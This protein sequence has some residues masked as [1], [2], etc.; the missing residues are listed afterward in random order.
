MSLDDLSGSNITNTAASTADTSDQYDTTDA[1]D[2]AVSLADGAPAADP[3][4]A[5]RMPSSAAQYRASNDPVVRTASDLGPAENF[6]L[7][8]VTFSDN[9]KLS[10]GTGMELGVINLPTYT[11]DRSTGSQI[12]AFVVSR[13][14]APQGL[15]GVN[16]IGYTHLESGNRSFELGPTQTRPADWRPGATNNDDTARAP[17]N[18]LA[19]SSKM[20]VTLPGENTLPRPNQ[21]GSSDKPAENG[22]IQGVAGTRHPDDAAQLAM[23]N[24]FGEIKFNAPLKAEK[25]ITNPGDAA[26]SIPSTRVEQRLPAAKTIQV[27]PGDGNTPYNFAL[28][29]DMEN[30]I[31]KPDTTRLPIP[32]SEV[33]Q[34]GT[35]V[36][37]TGSNATVDRTPSLGMGVFDSA[38]RPRGDQRGTVN[39]R[40]LDVQNRPE[41]QSQGRSLVEEAARFSMPDTTK[42][43]TAFENANAVG[44]ATS[45]P[46][47]Q[48]LNRRQSVA[49][50]SVT[51]PDRKATDGGQLP[52]IQKPDQKVLPQI[53]DP[54]GG[55]NQPEARTDRTNL[56]NNPWSVLKDAQNTTRNMDGRSTTADQRSIAGEQR[57]A[58]IGTGPNSVGDSTRRAIYSAANQKSPEIA[59]AVANELTAK[60]RTDAK[61]VSTN[62]V[63][64]SL[65]TTRS[66]VATTIKPVAIKL[67][68]DKSP[69]DKPSAHIEAGS[70]VGAPGAGVNKGDAAALRVVRNDSIKAPASAVDGNIVKTVKPTGAKAML[71]GNLIPGGA[72]A[73]GIKAGADKA[74]A[75]AINA[76]RP[77][78]LKSITEKV[79]GKT[80]NGVWVGRKLG[81]ERSDTVGTTNN[82]GKASG[83]KIAGEKAESTNTN[84]RTSKIGAGRLVGEIT[85]GR[86]FGGNKIGSAKFIGDIADARVPAGKLGTAFAGSKIIG[87]KSGAVGTDK[88]DSKADNKAFIGNKIGSSKVLVGEKVDAK[89]IIA[90]NKIGATKVGE[91]ADAKAVAA[92][93]KAGVAKFVGEK[94]DTK[95]I[96]ANNKIG[97]TKVGE[98]ADAK[99]IA[100]GGKVGVAKVAGEKADAKAIAAS[101]KV[102][103][104]KVAGEK[105]DAAKAISAQRV[106][107]A[108]VGSAEKAEVKAE[109]KAAA[110]IAKAIVN[111]NKLD[112][113]KSDAPVKGGKAA[114][115]VASAAE[116][117]QIK[118]AMPGAARTGGERIDST[119]GK[120]R[121]LDAVAKIFGIALGTEKSGSA[122]DNL[123]SR[124]AKPGSSRSE[125]ERVDNKDKAAA[126]NEDNARRVVGNGSLSSELLTSELGSDV[127]GDTEDNFKKK[128]TKNSKRTSAREAQ[129]ADKLQWMMQI[130][131]AG[132][133]IGDRRTAKRIGSKESQVLFKQAGRRRRRYTVK[134]GDNIRSIARVQLGDERFAQ[135]IITI[136][137]GSAGFYMLPDNKTPHLLVDQ[138]IWLPSDA[139]M[140]IHKKHHF[141]RG[142][143][144]GEQQNAPALDVV[145][146]NANT[147]P[148]VEMEIVK[149]PEVEFM[150][151]EN[152]DAYAPPTVS[153][154]QYQ[155]EVASILQR[156][157]NVG[158][159]HAITLQ[160]FEARCESNSPDSRRVYRVRL[161]D[162]LRSIALRD[163]LMQDQSLWPLIARINGI[164]ELRD[165]TTGHPTVSLSRGNT[166]Y[167]PSEE[168]VK[169]FRLMNRLATY[170]NNAIQCTA[171]TDLLATDPSYNTHPSIQNLSYSCRINSSEIQ[172]DDSYVSK[173]EMQ[174]G[175]EWITVAT[176]DYRHGHAFRYIHR[177]NGSVAAFPMDLP[178]E[179]V[180]EMSREDFARNWTTYCVDFATVSSGA[181]GKSS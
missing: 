150:Q 144:A 142:T 51:H 2:V 72:K 102:G 57:G 84:I 90:N 74:E 6:K 71:E 156:L 116:G 168:E 178:L 10:Q 166:I 61:L 1:Q 56:N 167:L 100:V 36:S 130:A 177:R 22:E 158:N 33:K 148:E 135:L 106:G 73:P 117:K 48:D 121:P 28:R 19:F 157:R 75:I 26:D 67:A 112:N 17:L 113:A 47:A 31:G 45:K 180:R 81:G 52:V 123:G 88:A 14:G 99:A 132:L 96:I 126:K 49:G 91:K 163:P 39:S 125:A 147:I 34:P 54:K 3:F 86:V 80:V 66:D 176:Y 161:G 120:G 174:I 30:A 21:I 15:G 98:K 104:A 129:T 114:G 171:E 146:P 145:C 78:G 20:P 43:K 18:P 122:I 151:S 11:P 133:N 149:L 143:V 59:R 32:V 76:I 109:A 29:G 169:H 172:G 105:A 42:V 79:E 38:D 110:K 8:G 12:G 7:P 159:R 23:F 155:H 160:E 58:Q 119:A 111:N 162:T 128:D 55:I 68:G 92:T 124:S 25:P 62:G 16:A 131:E 70:R 103:A 95:S 64:P 141:A 134:Y 181:S 50:G 152:T 94:V 4:S 108:K 35:I 136:N 170:A 27:G 107:A 85:E 83:I 41:I 53:I 89:S 165:G 40:T 173:L 65:G 137:R 154:E 46:A 24:R 139:E 140:E 69:I 77:G 179:I 63:F 153:Y 101:G 164:S 115:S 37:Q 60:P 97:A 93:F 175:G 44:D 9:S 13:I 127:D 87:S 138:V 5:Y 118:S 82:A